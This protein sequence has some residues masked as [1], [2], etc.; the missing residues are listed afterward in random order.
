MWRR[1]P[2]G[3]GCRGVDEK[4]PVPRRNIRRHQPLQLGR[5]HLAGQHVGRHLDDRVGA[6][7]ARERGLYASE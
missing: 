4:R 1:T 3:G 6:K 5:D 7:P 2:D